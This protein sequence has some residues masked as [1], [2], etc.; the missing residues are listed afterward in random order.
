MPEI[1]PLQPGDPP[2]LGDYPLAGRL[3][4]G[5]QGVVYLAHGPDGQPVAIKLLR[6]QLDRDSKAHARFAREVSIA[7]R[8]AP[9][10]TARV[11]SAD[12][13]GEAPYIVSEYVEGPSLLETVS[14]KGPLAG[15]D[16]DRLAVSTA[17]ALAAI[18][19][20]GIVH[21]DFKPGNVLLAADGPRVIDFGIARVLDATS[22][23]TS[24]V[25]GTPAF[26][27]PEQ[28]NDEEIG[29]PSDMFAWGSTI[30]YAA[31]GTSP[32][33]GNTITAVLNRI[34][35]HEPDLAALADPLRRVVTAALSK[36]PRQRPTPR[37][38]LDHMVS[39]G[40]STF[41]A[42]RSGPV[43]PPEPAARTAAATAPAS[44]PP[45]LA[46]PDQAATA[47]LPPAPGAARTRALAPATPA[48]PPS[49]KPA[50]G[51]ELIGPVLGSLVGLYLLG[52]ATVPGLMTAAPGWRVVQAE[53]GLTTPVIVFMFAA[54]LVAAMLG[55]PVGAVLGKR[56]AGAVA[57][58]AAGLMLLG[59][60]ME[61]LAPGALLL[62]IGKIISGLGMGA[63]VVVAVVLTRRT[64]RQWTYLIGWLGVIAFVLGPVLGGVL[65]AT[66][67]RQWAFL[68][69]VPPLLLAVLASLI[70]AINQAAAGPAN[71]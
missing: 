64:G 47:K 2:R 33:S 46:P 4:E 49:A 41:I 12:L 66:L 43:P 62:T 51:W 70:N 56:S 39:G 1:R 31:T 22:T 29:P 25:I 45:A 21:R 10:C 7:E 18:H 14:D 27:S 61:F 38:V 52:V 34:V 23:I 42:G 35:N 58:N 15:A 68:I 67:G 71:R 9:F 20:A 40:A 30:V 36:D 69:S 63:L 53:M 60:L 65:T 26:M 8:V 55:A 37:E 3:G 19:E 16:L 44:V 57:A 54:Y 28:V 24:R 59:V 32:F 5:G 11:I 6:T 48:T 17:T 50:G 13:I